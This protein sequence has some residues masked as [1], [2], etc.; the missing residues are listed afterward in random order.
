MHTYLA[1]I[2]NGAR[3]L[4][5][6]PEKPRKVSVLDFANPFSAGLGLK[7]PRGD[8]AWLHWE[9]NVDASHF[10]PPEQYF[11]DVEV[12]MLPKWGINNEPLRELYHAY[13]D[14]AFEPIRENNGWTIYRRRMQDVAAKAAL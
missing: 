4:E 9:R 13:I 1:S 5:S 12:L 6:L 10:F 11:A 14:E 2:E 8:S 7:P 3:I